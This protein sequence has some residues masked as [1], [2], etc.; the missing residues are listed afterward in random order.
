M[1]GQEPRRWHIAE[2]NPL[3]SYAFETELGG[4]VMAFQWRFDEIAGGT[5]LTQHIVLKGENAATYAPQVAAAF[6]TNLAAGMGRIAA[7]IEQAESRTG[8]SA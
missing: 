7:A 4:A 5:R 6:A 2:V 8:A 3:Q 1:P